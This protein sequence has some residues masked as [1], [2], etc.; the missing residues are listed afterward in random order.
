MR[1]GAN[2]GVDHRVVAVHLGQRKLEGFA[3]RVGRLGFDELREQAAGIIGQQPVARLGEA[4]LN[5]AREAARP[6]PDQQPLLPPKTKR[7][8]DLVR[9]VFVIGLPA[10]RNS[11]ERDDAGCCSGRFWPA[12][13]SSERV[14]CVV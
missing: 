8:E 6:R 14:V 7:P 5:A 9:G 11:S 12:A 4:L 1:A 2:G 13:R 10:E 3:E